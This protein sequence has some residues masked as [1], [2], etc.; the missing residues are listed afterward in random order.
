MLWQWVPGVAP[1]L[2][3]AVLLSAYSV[4]SEMERPFPSCFDSHKD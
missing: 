1:V 4:L 3:L 2:R